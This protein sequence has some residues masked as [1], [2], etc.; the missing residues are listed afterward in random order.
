[1][2]VGTDSSKFPGAAE[3]GAAWTFDRAHELGLDGVF[4]RTP[5]ELSPTL[6]R[7][8]MAEAV[9]HA[10]DL[11][12]YV[13]VGIGKVNPFTA[14]E[15]PSSG[16]SATATTCGASVASSSWWPVSGSTTCGPPRA[17]TSS[18]SPRSL[19]ATGSAPT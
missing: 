14:P 1:M 8:Q 13:Q 17:T 5:W 19:P 15:L 2:R 9:A 6:D 18:A 3:H 11:G 7:G 4:L 16:R 10:R 12:L